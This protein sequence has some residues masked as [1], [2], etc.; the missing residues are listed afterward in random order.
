MPTARPKPKPRPAKRTITKSPRDVKVAV[1]A[2]LKKLW[3][4]T[5]AEIRK[6]KGRGAEAFDDLWEAV[7]KAV[8][9]DPPLY[10][11]GGYGSAREFFEEVLQEK[12]RTAYRLMRVAK[13]A[14]PREEAKY[15][16]TVLDAALGYI[17]ATTGGELSGPLPVAFERLRIPVVRGGETV[18][19]P[20]EEATA[21]EISKAARIVAA[22]KGKARASSDPVEAALRKALAGNAST[23]AARATVRGGTV[24]FSG[25][26]VASLVAFAKLLASVK[27]PSSAPKTVKSARKKAPS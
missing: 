19:L 14:S 26:P 10:V 16:T 21:E 9:H 24:T 23:K 17:E 12:P 20:L 7:A 8:E 1:D 22:K 13:Y 6:A 4:A 25:L 27:L 5:L 18:K 15:G 11:L 3:D 2:K